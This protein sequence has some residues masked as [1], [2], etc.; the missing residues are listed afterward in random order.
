MRS[1]LRRAVDTALVVVLSLLATACG[2]SAT[3][4][5]TGSSPFT[6]TID[7]TAWSSSSS[8]AVGVA[9]GVFTIAGA[10]ASGTALS[11]TLYNIGKPGTYPLGVGG[12]IFGGTAVISKGA[13]GWWTALTGIAGSVTITAVSGTHI[14]GMFSFNATPLTGGAAGT[15]SVTNGSF[16]I[17][18]SSSVSVA[19]PANAGNAV[20]A[21]LGGQPWNAATAV[22][23]GAPSS[24]T[25]FVGWTNDTYSVNLSVTGFTGIGTYVMNTGVARYFSV[26][27]TGTNKTWG[28]SGATNTGSVVVTSVS[29]SRVVG[30]F[31]VTLQPGGGSPGTG[32]LTFVGAF[33]LGI[34]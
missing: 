30:T 9:S 23:V 32:N 24:G 13:D 16:D 6:A 12:T 17:D 7:G 14:A 22:M 10:D 25:L 33:D 15:R 20:A 11:L 3:G 28:W 29:A 4:P 21:T 2:K 18:V 8:S 1:P 27:Q 31:N 19:A 5:G 26:T 34:P